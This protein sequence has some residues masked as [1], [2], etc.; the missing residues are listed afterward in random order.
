M[1]REKEVVGDV[2]ASCVACSHHQNVLQ[3]TLHEITAEVQYI[4]GYPPK[5]F[6]ENNKTILYHTLLRREVYVKGSIH[7]DL[8]YDSVDIEQYPEA[9]EILSVLNGDWTIPRIQFYTA[10]RSISESG[11]RDLIF[12]I[13]IRADVL[14][15]STEGLPSIDD[16]FSTAE[17]SAKLAFG[18]MCH[19]VLPRCIV[20]G[21]PT[22]KSMAPNDLRTGRSIEGSTHFRVRAQR[23]SWR[24][25]CVML[26]IDK[27]L[28]IVLLVWFGIAVEHLIYRMD[29]LDERGKGLYDLA[30]EHLCPI[31]ACQQFLADYIRK[32][33][34][35]G[36][37]LLPIF[38]EF[39]DGS[40]VQDQKLLDRMR[41]MSSDMGS[42]IFFRFLPLQ[43]LPNTLT[44]CVNPALSEDRQRNR[45]RETFKMK[46]CCRDKDCSEK[47]VAVYGNWETAY[48]NEALMNG[49]RTFAYLKRFM[50]MSSER[51]LALMRRSIG[52]SL[53]KETMEGICSKG[54]LCQLMAHHRQR[55]GEDPKTT[56][57]A[58]L[59]EDGVPI[60]AAKPAK[61]PKQ[62]G[63]FIQFKNEADAVR[64][65]GKVRFTRE[66]YKRWEAALA[67]KWAQ[68]STTD[69]DMVLQNV[70]SNYSK[71]RA[72]EESDTPLVRD[73]GVY[74]TLVSACGD[75]SNPFC[76]DW[77][78]HTLQHIMGLPDDAPTPA[79]TT[80]EQK[81]RKLQTDQIWQS[82]VGA[83]GADEHFSY[84]VPCPLAHP[85]IC[86]YRDRQYMKDIHKSVKC[87][88]AHLKEYPRGSIHCLWSKCAD[89]TVVE[90]LKFL[91]CHYHGSSPKI[92]LTCP[93]VVSHSLQNNFILEMA[94]NS[95]SI[96]NWE[97]D[98]TM[99]G[100]MF[101]QVGHCDF[102]LF[103]AELK[104]D[105]SVVCPRGDVVLLDRQYYCKL[106]R[107][108]PD[109][110]FHKIHPPCAAV[111]SSASPA[112][113]SMEKGMASVVANNRA[114]KV[115]KPKGIIVKMPASGMLSGSDGESKHEGSGSE[116]A[117]T[118]SS[119]SA[120]DTG[121]EAEQLREEVKKAKRNSLVVLAK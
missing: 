88:R 84:T 73:P 65:K 54:F 86:A 80:F 55:G 47:L 17:H 59:L 50:N 38:R 49:L 79:F 69:R 115:R 70:R 64:K 39:S 98:I 51:L 46:D 72:I 52:G 117:R 63:T 58:Q 53:G 85:S 62:C 36:S 56:S 94:R 40:V 61:S 6:Y 41:E 48:G 11:A 71:K 13:L 24:T 112:V 29:Y 12:G 103:Y 83:I 60:R 21:L 113:K 105:R 110:D 91:L 99:V 18:T 9:M 28:S 23:K 75:K 32:G 57:R 104:R 33:K 67:V 78:K 92:A 44:D 76:I 109:V 1:S 119:N 107:P 14:L 116:S 114:E 90:R 42:Q 43:N 111:K 25:R 26:A 102:S 121:S 66:Q 16:W 95:R 27:K 118:V 35:K 37:P 20:K 81:V 108:N 120:S 34:Q 10:G 106:L 96:C 97:F 15:S 89:G 3:S 74:T 8:F 30:C 22:W 82:D 101:R 68:Q 19:S 5:H 93:L 7:N 2:H 87:L 100:Q 4:V 77:Y 31:T 45:M